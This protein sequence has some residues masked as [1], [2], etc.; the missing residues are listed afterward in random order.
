MRITQKILNAKM[1]TLN[2]VL[3]QPTEMFKGK[4]N[5]YKTDINVGHMALDHNQYYGYQV[6]QISEG[7]GCTIIIQRCSARE[8]FY[9]INGMIDGAH[10]IL[11]QLES[12]K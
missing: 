7:G 12:L 8:M 6:E 1:R 9:A 3:S 11:K 10:R 4:S 5:D 2:E